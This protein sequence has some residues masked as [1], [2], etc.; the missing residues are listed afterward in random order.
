MLS[1]FSCTTFMLKRAVTISCLLILLTGCSSRFA[2]NNLDWLAYWYLDD[3]VELERDQKVVFDQN[4]DQW[5]HWHREQELG[6]YQQHLSDLRQQI[7]T[8]PVSQQQWLLH[9]ERGRGHWERLWDQISPELVEFAVLLNDQQVDSLFAEITDQR[10]ETEEEY[11]DVEPDERLDERQQQM[12]QQLERWVGDISR[13]QKDIVSDYAP[14]FRPT[15]ES[16]ISY[17]RRMDTEARQLFEQRNV[18]P[19]FQARLLHLLQNA[20]DYK[21]QQ[22]IEN[23]DHNRQ[24]IAHMSAV[25]SE[26]LSEKQRKH[27]N[28]KLEDLI[29]DIEVLL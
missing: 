2:Y 3:Y 7:N 9:F 25:I 22:H 6:Q 24:L 4:L 10:G 21:S 16:Q 18:I 15:F 11:N 12:E 19:D 17:Q 26:T 8:G 28:G 23:A 27:A 20:N 1:P 5:L 29:S 13:L 14:R